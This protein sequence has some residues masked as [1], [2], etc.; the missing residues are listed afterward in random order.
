MPFGHLPLLEYQGKR[1]PESQ[2]IA[3]FLAQKYGLAGKDELEQAQVDAIADLYKD[4]GSK[5]RSYFN[6]L[7]GRVPGDKVK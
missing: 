6:V 5:I 7:M 2:A 1:L 4:F 3:R